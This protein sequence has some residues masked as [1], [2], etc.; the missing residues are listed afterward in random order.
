[1][2]PRVEHGTESEVRRDLAA[3][4]RLVAREGWDDLIYSHVTAMVPDEPDHFLINA[5]GLSFH[6]ISAASLVKVDLAGNVVYAPPGATINRSG[7]AL[8]AAIHRARPDAVCVMHLHEPNAIA[9]STHPQGLLPLSQHALRF[10]GFLALHDY[11]GVAFTDDEATRLLPRLAGKPAAL[12]RN[13]GSLVLGRTVPEAYVLTATLIKACRIQIA[14]LAGNP[15]PHLPTPAVIEKAA[16][17]L[18]DN[19]ALEGVAEWPSLL[20][21]VGAGDEGRR[22]GF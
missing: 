7:A 13:H 9:V 15:H 8:H 3:A 17:Q 20:R 18:D 2:L 21:S 1:M 14:A 12:L 10:H 19:G 4:Y 5:F 22:A 6:E 11:E 16:A